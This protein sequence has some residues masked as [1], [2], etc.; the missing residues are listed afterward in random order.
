[1]KYWEPSQVTVPVQIALLSENVQEIG[2]G[3]QVIIFQ[4]AVL[5]ITEQCQSCEPACLSR[6]NSCLGVLHH[7]AVGRSN[8]QLGCGTQEHF[9]VRLGV[10]NVGTVSNGIK[11]VTQ[12]DPFQN[13]LGVLTGGTDAQLVTT[14]A[15]LIEGITN[16]FASKGE[17]IVETNIAAFKAGYEFAQK[18]K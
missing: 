18:N 17:A 14:V 12:T 4:T 2:E 13:E 15:Q 10:S 9:R 6:L 3:L 8:A 1:M 7:G 11:E 5:C 16:V